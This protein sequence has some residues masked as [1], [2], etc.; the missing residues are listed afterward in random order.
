VVAALIRAPVTWAGL[1]YVH[2]PDEPHNIEIAQRMAADDELNPR[3]FFYPA[4]M[5]DIEWSVMSATHDDV[6]V[7]QTP[8]NSRALRPHLMVV[9]RW[10]VGVLPG[11][12]AVAAVGAVAW[13]ASRRWWAAGLAAGLMAL[14]PLELRFG[15]LVTPDAWAGAASGL[16]VLGAISVL[17][18]PQAWRYLLA[19]TAVGL[20]TS[21]KYNAV[22]GAVPLL[23]AHGLSWR[24]NQARWRW[25]A[26]AAVASVVVFVIVNPYALLDRHAFVAG[27][28]RESRHYRKG[29]AGSEGGSLGHHLSWLWQGFGPALLLAP[30]GLFAKDRRVRRA[31]I[32]ALSLVVAYV[33]FIS[34]FEVRFARNLLPATV[35][36][37]G[38]A[39]LGAV[40]IGERLSDV[41]ALRRSVP[42]AIAACCALLLAWPALAAHDAF[43]SLTEDHW[44]SA[45]RWLD[46]NVPAGSRVAVGAY[47]IYVD[48]ARYDVTPVPAL[49]SH[50]LAWYRDQDIT[51][52][53]AGEPY[54]HRFLV[55]PH[56]YPAEAAAY[57]EFLDQVCLLHATGPPDAQVLFLAPHP[58]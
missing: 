29:H 40:A 20:A 26:P 43:G 4:L 21:A 45:E 50:D 2:H 1:P 31:A 16:V 14:S 47:S 8:G 34:S 48:P 52:I 55:D 41:P 37:A 39:A 9:V 6:I 22:L 28:A 27:V 44:A 5:Y 49:I 56:R 58:C 24:L 3:E 51:V 13:V 57:Q 10:L 11:L 38:A 30:L 15:P 17:D 46:E 33:G 7:T 23:V 53:V 36:L 18:R 12:V 54:F 19:G 42:S 25:L 32:V 35:V